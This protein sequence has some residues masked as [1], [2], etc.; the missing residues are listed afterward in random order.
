[1]TD[2]PVKLEVDVPLPL[3]KAFDAFVHRFS[4]WW[5]AEYT[6]SQGVLESIDIEPLVGGRCTEFGPNG[7]QLDWGQVVDFESPGK[8]VF[9]WQIDP[10]RVPQPDPEKSSMVAVTFHATDSKTTILKLAHSEFDNHGVGSEG[11][12]EAMNSDMGWRYIINKYLTYVS[13]NEVN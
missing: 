7:F 10:N 2:V 13:A 12:R 11:Y 1:M 6:W 4:Q 5:P 3:E 8:I 9:R